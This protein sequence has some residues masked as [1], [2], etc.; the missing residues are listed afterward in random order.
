MP[1]AVARAPATAAAVMALLTPA[2]IIL[3]GGFARTD[4]PRAN[5]N[6]I[7]RGAPCECGSMTDQHAACPGCQGGVF[8]PQGRGAA[9]PKRLHPWDIDTPR[10]I[11]AQSHPANG[12]DDHE[13]VGEARTH[14]AC[15]VVGVDFASTLH[16]PRPPVAATRAMTMAAAIVWGAGRPRRPIAAPS[17]TA[18]AQL[19]TAHDAAR[20][21][22]APMEV[23]V[24]MEDSPIDA[25]GDGHVVHPHRRPHRRPEHLLPVELDATGGPAVHAHRACAMG[26]GILLWVIRTDD[27]LM[28]GGVDGTCT[29]N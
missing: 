14:D 15:L 5:G 12:A 19:P 13:G 17:Q 18:R 1:A 21:L 20:L 7:V 11:V 29:V 23:G 2:K 10:R 26:E 6:G 3:N 24:S 22:G 28:V 16:C 25:W 4:L 27:A 9:V 8:H